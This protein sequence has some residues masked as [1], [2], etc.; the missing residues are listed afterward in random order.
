M[1]MYINM[2][3]WMQSILATSSSSLSNVCAS[4]RT[5]VLAIPPVGWSGILINA[6]SVTDVSSTGKEFLRTSVDCLL[7]DHTGDF[8][9]MNQ[10]VDTRDALIG[11]DGRKVLYCL[12]VFSGNNN[13][14][15]FLLNR[16]LF[17]SNFLNGVH[18]QIW[19]HRVHYINKVL[20]VWKGIVLKV[21]KVF[22]QLSPLRSRFNAPPDPLSRELLPIRKVFHPLHIR[23]RQQLLFPAQH[24]PSE[25]RR[26]VP[27]GRCVLLAVIIEEVHEGLTIR[28]LLG[29]LGRGHL[30]HL[31]LP[32][33]LTWIQ[34]RVHELLTGLLLGLLR[35]NV[36]NLAVLIALTIA[37]I[38]ITRIVV[39]NLHLSFLDIHLLWL[40]L[41]RFS[42]LHLS[43]V[44]L[45]PLS[46]LLLFLPT[47]CLSACRHSPWLLLCLCFH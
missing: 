25:S 8:L 10:S 39:E 7:A 13:W 43:L 28:A 3:W 5:L 40:R 16:Y 42:F 33:R 44:F 1:K 38:V 6:A 17:L 41:Y 37:P 22:C 32:H 15:L 24:V 47:V 27:E 35:L 45:L 14:G 4:D 9:L 21:R 12:V 29:K 20:F 18:D 31:H 23:L 19:N 46:H 34:N 2:K 11:S 30:V 36:V 26:H